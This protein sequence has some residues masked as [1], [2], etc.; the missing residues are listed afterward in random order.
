[1]NT[2]AVARIEWD[3]RE[4]LPRANGELVF[5]EPWE[6]R[7]FGMAATLV[8][9]KVFTWD[10]FREH[11]VARIEAWQATVD[12]TAWS[13]Y[14]CWL[15]ALESVLVE[16]S[17]LGSSDVTDLAHELALRPAGHDHEGGHEDD[18]EHGHGH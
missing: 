3:G 2:A 8:E 4:A 18:H 14:C 7:A 5:A 9:S 17:V 10:E 12:E 15:D 6:S 1:M 11:L 16:R 13:Y